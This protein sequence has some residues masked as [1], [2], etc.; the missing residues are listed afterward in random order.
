MAS[1][2]SA[3]AHG[4]AGGGAGGGMLS[5]P[6]EQRLWSAPFTDQRRNDLPKVTEPLR[7][8]ARV[9]FCLDALPG[10]SWPPLHGL[11]WTLRSVCQAP[12]EA[13]PGQ[14]RG[15]QAVSSQRPGKCPVLA[16]AGQA[17]LDQAA[18]GG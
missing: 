9:P 8:G 14:Q 17:G 3:P 7:D 1:T 10:Q 15:R 4:I 6:G 5:H 18:S 12:G 16:G 2:D 11:L 13:P